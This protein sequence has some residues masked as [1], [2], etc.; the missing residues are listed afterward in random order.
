MHIFVELCNSRISLLLSDTNENNND[1]AGVVGDIEGRNSNDKTTTKIS[2]RDKIRATKATQGG[3]YIQ[4]ISS[5]LLSSL[6]EDYTESLG[7]EV[8]GEFRCSYQ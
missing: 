6:Q 5:V 4:V 1:V 7:V 2:L 8:G 3:S